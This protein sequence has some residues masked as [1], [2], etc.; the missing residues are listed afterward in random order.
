MRWVH[1]KALARASEF[2]IQVRRLA[3]RRHVRCWRHPLP[4]CA[5]PL[6][7]ISPHCC[8]PRDPADAPS[9]QGV[10]Y[11]L[12]QG[13]VKNIIPAIASTN[14]IGEPPL[15]LRPRRHAAASHCGPPSS[16]LPASNQV[17]LIACPALLRPQPQQEAVVLPPLIDRPPAPAVAA[18][19]ALEALKMVTM[20]S[21]GLNNYM[22]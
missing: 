22:M 11:Q 1:D 20:C 12:T 4:A 6:L 17:S 10:T 16:Q 18:Q 2:G 21:S 15:L 13:V 3:A 14:A 8:E 19:C 7:H 9:L 5:M